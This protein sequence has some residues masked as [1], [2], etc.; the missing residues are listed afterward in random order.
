MRM[1]VIGASGLLGRHTVQ[2]ALTAGHEVVAIG[3]SKTSL[4]AIEQPN[5]ALRISDMGDAASLRAALENVNAVINCAGYYPTVPRPWQEEVDAALRGM[6]TFYEV[7]ES[8]PL[9][10]VVYVGAA[11]ALPRD[12]SGRP[13]T[14][15]LD[16][17]EP[18]SHHS[19][20]LQVKWALDKQ[21]REAAMRGLP[22]SIGIPTMSFGEYDVGKT[23]GRLILEM[24]NNT[25]PGFVEG[26]RNVIYA[27]DAGRGLVRV[28]EDGA[29]GER[30]LLAGENLT[31]SELMA[32][33]SKL[34]G[35]AMP[36]RIPL[37][38]ARLIS[39][40]QSARYKFLSGPEPTVSESAIAVMASGQFISGEKAK[41][42]LNFAS[43][44]NVDEAIERTLAWFKKLGLV[45]R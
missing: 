24:A 5:V 33:I 11:I 23:T 10:K 32:K 12:P 7:C 4:M 43:Q 16:Y 2:A 8:L 28:A 13:G 22:V 3:R 31:M 35:T 26:R 18:P 34:T 19:P 1:A 14:E 9:T 27:G 6:K 37:P 41:R 15:A 20:Y 45:T 30:Y 44:V 25:L 29:V 21:A 39:S 36:K 17:A 40:I 42:T 38:V